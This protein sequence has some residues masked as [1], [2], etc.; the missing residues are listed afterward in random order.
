[1]TRYWL[2]IGV[3]ALVVFLVGLVV[4]SIV[5]RGR[6]EVASFFSTDRPI[7][8]PL[9]G[10]VPFSVDG[11]E[12]GRIQRITFMRDAP[13]QISG[14]IIQVK[15]GG[16]IPPLAFEDCAFTVDD[17]LHVDEHTQFRC[18]AEDSALAVL[19]PFGEVHFVGK[20]GTMSRMIVLPADVIEK[21][22]DTTEFE[23][24]MESAGVTEEEAAERADSIAESME[25]LGDSISREVEV[26]VREALKRVEEG[27]ARVQR[28]RPVE[29]AQPAPA[30]VTP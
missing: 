11:N 15:N 3:G 20:H 26:K 10:I 4:W 28:E 14:V 1:M 9:L 29:P 2:K 17:P 7:T 22:R 13:K 23:H 30:P 5:E 6:D 8:L 25:G 18:L 12:A 19:Q 24:R 16:S 27:K 21:L